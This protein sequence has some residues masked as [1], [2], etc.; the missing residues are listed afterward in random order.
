[1]NPRPLL[2]TFFSAFAALS[3]PG[4][5]AFA[6]SVSTTS[7]PNCPAYFRNLTHIEIG[8]QHTI[9]EMNGT[10]WND[11]AVE[12]EHLDPT[13]DARVILRDRD[14]NVLVFGKFADS[15]NELGY[16]IPFLESGPSG[17]R[18]VVY[19]ALDSELEFELTGRTVM[20]RLDR[21]ELVSLAEFHADAIT[22]FEARQELERA[23]ELAKLKLRLKEKRAFMAADE[24]H[25]TETRKME[26]EESL[27]KTPL[28][29]SR[30]LKAPP[31][32]FQKMGLLDI[33]LGQTDRNTSN[34][35]VGPH[36][37]VLAIDNPRILGLSMKFSRADTFGT[38]ELPRLALGAVDPVVKA[39]ILS[40]TPKRLSE[41]LTDHEIPAIYQ[42][43]SKRN[44]ARV[45][46]LLR[47]NASFDEILNDATRFTA[48]DVLPV[49]I[50]AAGAGGGIYYLI[51]EKKTEK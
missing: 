19:H 36:G 10:M 30:I 40:L 1:M 2:N 35:M 31:E 29:Q 14:D 43:F 25:T 26:L 8:L 5:F 23:R 17:K 24:I 47:A 22:G 48:G 39:K 4:H 12:I 49:A 21:K 41:I 45:Q 33:I 3:L 37:K 20:A 28:S 6:G 7:K 34:W 32:A 44:L 11:L 15:K 46:K 18:E 16:F 50:G 42:Y 9:T 51:N 13:R 27:R 38:E